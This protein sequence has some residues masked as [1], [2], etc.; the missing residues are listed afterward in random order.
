MPSV[1]Q[2][3]EMKINKK[4]LHSISHNDTNTVSFTSFTISHAY[5]CYKPLANISHIIDV[6]G[7]CKRNAWV[8]H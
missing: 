7:Q 8:I 6:A 5:A 1:R 2:V 4:R 3:G